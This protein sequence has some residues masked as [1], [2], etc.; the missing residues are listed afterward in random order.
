[1]S[2]STHDTGTQ[3]VLPLCRLLS[4]VEAV[5]T[6]FMSRLAAEMFSIN[7]LNNSSRAKTRRMLVINSPRGKWPAGMNDEEGT[8]W[9]SYKLCAVFETISRHPNFTAQVMIH[10][11][12]HITRYLE[13]SIFENAKPDCNTFM[14]RDSRSKYLRW[15]V[16]QFSLPNRKK[17]KNISIRPRWQRVMFAWKLRIELK[18]RKYFSENNG[19]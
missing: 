2:T 6:V 11:H 14:H 4:A 1:M 8:D 9:N 12:A 17:M 16:S 7:N 19:R 10:F 18:A 15:R 13:V 3:L 5:A